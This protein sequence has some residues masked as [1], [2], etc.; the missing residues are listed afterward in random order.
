MVTLPE[1]V[2]F[3]WRRPKILSSMFFLVNRYLALVGN[4]FGLCI[5]FLPAVSD[6]SC[7]RYMLVRELF[8]FLQQI[9]VC[10]TLTLL[11]YA[12]Y[13][14][15]R[16]LLSCMMI[17]GLALI[18]GAS[19]GSFGNNSNVATYVQGSDCHNTLTEETAIR[20]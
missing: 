18:G 17:I 8:L 19:A 20:Q 3:I 4:I 15:S 1:E 13:D 14:R 11:I 5:D 6:E 2:A 16:R 10:L 9:I 12:L 7:S